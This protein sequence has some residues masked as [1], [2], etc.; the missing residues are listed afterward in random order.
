MA[1]GTS[2]AMA[3]PA[4]RRERHNAAHGA[5]FFHAL[6]HL[7]PGLVSPAGKEWAELVPDPFGSSGEVFT[8]EAD[9]AL[10]PTST[11]APNE[12][13]GFQARFLET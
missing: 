4:V 6:S 10:S 8:L 7:R 11:R 2:Q 1:G 5:G 9:D 3:A 13:C 12:A